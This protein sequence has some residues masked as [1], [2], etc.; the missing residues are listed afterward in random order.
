MSSTI[1]PVTPRSYLVTVG[2][3]SV[4]AT[5]R[6]ST[7]HRVPPWSRQYGR[8]KEPSLS[9]TCPMPTAPMR[10]PKALSEGAVL[11]ASLSTAHSVYNRHSPGLASASSMWWIIRPLPT[12]LQRLVAW[13][14]HAGGAGT[15]QQ[16]PPTRFWHGAGTTGRQRRRASPLALASLLAPPRRHHTEGVGGRAIA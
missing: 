6:Y 15:S 16:P 2:L 5:P 11:S 10:C 9:L 3:S 8:V 12:H 1:R 7:H 4:L 14:T 13:R